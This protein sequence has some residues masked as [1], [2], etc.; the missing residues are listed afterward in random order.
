MYYLSDI[1]EKVDIPGAIKKGIKEACRLM[2]KTHVPI[3]GTGGIR[4]F[5]K[6]MRRWPEKY[7][8]RRAIL[9]LGHTIRMQEE[10]GTGGGG[11]RLMYAAF[12]HESA[13]ILG[14][15]RLFEMSKRMTAIGDR[16][17]EF[18]LHGAR[19][20]KNR[21]SDGDNFDLLSNIVLDCSEQ[22]RRFF[23]DLSGMVR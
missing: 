1:R 5:G 4:W 14:D 2:I 11:F 19:I 23:S 20:C 7:G 9:Y 17:R 3:I 6:G 21:S 18:A 10:I 15:D 8:E 13:H 22:E 12:L 16:W